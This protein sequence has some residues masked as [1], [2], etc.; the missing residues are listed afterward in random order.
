MRSGGQGADLLETRGWDGLASGVIESSYSWSSSFLTAAIWRSSNSV[1][2]AAPA[3]CGADERA[4]HEF[5]HRLFAEAV[6]DDFEPSPLLDEQPFEQ[7][8]RPG[9]A[10]MRDRQAQVGDAGP[11]VVVKTGERA[12]KDI[13]VAGA[14]ARRQLACDRPRGRLIAGG[15]PRLELR[16]QVGGDLGREVEHPVRQAALARRAR[17]AFLNRALSYLT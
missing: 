12:G 1:T 4:E 6:G 5:E 10:P 8:G 3:L 11:E 13:G 9:E 7:V 17:K 15:D 14:D 2:Q 16:P